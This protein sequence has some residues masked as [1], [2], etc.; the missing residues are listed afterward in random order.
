MTLDQGC[1]VCKVYT[2]TRITIV[3]LPHLTY[4]IQHYLDYLKVDGMFLLVMFYEEKYVCLL[5]EKVIEILDPRIHLLQG[6]PQQVDHT[7]PNDALK[8]VIQEVVD[9]HPIFRE[10]TLESNDWLLS[11]DTDEYLYVPGTLCEFLQTVPHTITQVQ[12]PWVSVE[13]TSLWL[14][15]HPYQN[16][17]ELPWMSSSSF[18][19]AVRV[20]PGIHSNVNP[21][22][23]STPQGTTWTCHQEALLFHLHSLSMGTT[24]NKIFYHR[25]PGKSDHDQK[26]ILD[27]AVQR[28]DPKLF[29]SLYKIQLIYIDL[30]SGIPYPK[31]TLVP[32]FIERSCAGDKGVKDQI[33]DLEKELL[34]A[35]ID[36]YS[37]QWIHETFQELLHVT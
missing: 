20:F 32:R 2:I 17:L 29:M 19:S 33:R 36:P 7:L 21:H 30:K 13:N 10:A 35:R 11:L 34:Y 24:L 6:T 8:E 31:V 1:N 22:Y 4:F 18:K 23:F 27:Q 5:K 3:D 14:S 28:R 26:Q 37:V 16:I 15:E 9:T 12:F 25:I